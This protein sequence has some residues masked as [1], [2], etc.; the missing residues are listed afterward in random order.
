MKV[1]HVVECTAA[2][3]G[4]S[5]NIIC[6]LQSTEDLKN[7][8]VQ[9][10]AYIGV[11]HECSVPQNFYIQVRQTV[12]YLFLEKKQMPLVKRIIAKLVGHKVCDIVHLK[13][14]A[15]SELPHEDSNAWVWSQTTS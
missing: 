12:R 5:K 14:F 4:V 3:T 11:K 2:A 9:S 6:R 1:T 10:E 13:S 8:P 15:G 7:W